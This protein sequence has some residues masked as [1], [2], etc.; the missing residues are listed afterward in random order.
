MAIKE[1]AWVA[2]QRKAMVRLQALNRTTRSFLQQLIRG[3]VADDHDTQLHV[4][5]KLLEEELQR[6]SMLRVAERRRKQLRK[7]RR[8]AAKDDE[9]AAAEVVDSLLDEAREAYEWL[10]AVTA[11]SATMN[12]ESAPLSGQANPTLSEELPLLVSADRSGPKWQLDLFLGQLLG[13]RPSGED[14]V[15]DGSERDAQQSVA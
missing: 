13:P 8:L 5:L 3:P 1:A 12:G 7:A 9:G 11:A 4:I 2:F 6:Q 15:E 14:S 10:T